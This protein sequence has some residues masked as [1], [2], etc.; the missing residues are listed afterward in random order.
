MAGQVYEGTRRVDKAGDWLRPDAILHIKGPI[1]PY[2]SR[3]GLKLE[4]AI[5]SFAIDLTGKTIVDIGASTGGF[6]DC[7]L[8]HGAAKVTAVDVG[9]GQ[10][11]WSLREDPRVTVLERTNARSLTADLIGG[12]KDGA[13]IDVSFISLDKIFPVI[14]SLVSE[15]GFGVALIKPQFEAGKG[16]VGKKGV[17]RSEAAHEDVLE[18]VLGDLSKAALHAYG[19]TFSPIKGPQG[20]I[21]YLLWFGLQAGPDPISPG[22]HPPHAY[23]D[24][25]QDAFA[26][27]RNEE[28]ETDDA[29][30][31]SKTDSANDADSAN[32]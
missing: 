21:E 22:Y 18:K 2:V 25:I 4:K 23:R 1:M 7:A 31:A 20:N 17:L 9:Y 16:K 29:S 13:T 12:K 10:L 14:P 28:N 30:E 15:Q 11:S 19:L 6:T 3:G 27:L 5:R 32:D 8:R 24:L 26:Q